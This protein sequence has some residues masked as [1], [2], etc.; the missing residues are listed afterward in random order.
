MSFI[1]DT[2]V[3]QYPSVHPAVRQY[4]HMEATGARDATGQNGWYYPV[5]FVNTFWQLRTHMT[6]LNSTV[7]KLPLHINLNNFANWKFSIIASVDEGAKQTARN[8]AQGISSPGG[9][10]GSEFEMIKEVLLD[11][12]PILLGTTVVVSIFHMLFEMLAFKSDISHYRN[13][14]NN[15]GIS[16]RSILGNVFMQAVIFLYLLDNNENTSTSP[17]YSPPP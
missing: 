17:V 14:K 9:G 12:N 6:A 5:L 16:V 7:T 10:D 3:M 13:K 15:V 8:A 1:P 4:V 11:T 2:G